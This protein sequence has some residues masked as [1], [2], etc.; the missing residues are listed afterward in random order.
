MRLFGFINIHPKKYQCNYYN[1]EIYPFRFFKQIFGISSE[2]INKCQE[3]NVLLIK[4]NRNIAR[5]I[6]FLLYLL[7]YLPGIITIFAAKKK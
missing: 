4:N 2:V 6:S 3:K 1:D 5:F 7:Q